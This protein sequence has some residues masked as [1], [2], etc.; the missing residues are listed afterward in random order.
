M[1]KSIIGLIGI[2][3]AVVLIV[4]LAK[5]VKSLCTFFMYYNVMFVI[6]GVLAWYC[7]FSESNDVV[8]YGT[9]V[10]IVFASW[11]INKLYNKYIF[12]IKFKISHLPMFNKYRLQKE[13]DFIANQPNAPQEL[14]EHYIK[15]GA[16]IHNN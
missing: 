4:K 11:L 12:K 15:N 9:F 8:K 5:A 7:F 16:K 1:N 3:I 14:V 2:L 10:G 6:I 13:L